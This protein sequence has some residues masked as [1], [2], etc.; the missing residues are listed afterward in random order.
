MI[1]HDVVH[2]VA[3]GRWLALG[4]GGYAVAHVV[5]RVWSHVLAVAAHAPID[6]STPLPAHWRS[7]AA[8]TWGVTIP[9]TMGDGEPLPRV[10][11]FAAG[12]DPADDVDRAILATR[13]ATFPWHG[14]DPLLD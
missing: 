10:R 9:P 12:Y 5:P 6:V 7:H 14:L 13:S 11:P 2:E 4:G 8:E 3:G 1:L